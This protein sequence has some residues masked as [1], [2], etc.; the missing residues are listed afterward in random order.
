M[1]S[2]R[3][4]GTMYYAS[5]YLGG[6][7][8]RV[9]LGTTAFRV[10]KERLRKLEASLARGTLEEDRPTQTPLAD[11]V[12]AYAEYIRHTK[13]RNGQRIDLW[14]LRDIFGPVSPVLRPQGRLKKRYKRDTKLRAQ[15]LEEIRTHQIAEFIG[16]R[17]VERGI[18]PKTANRYREILMRLFNWAVRQRGLRLPGGINP[19]KAVERYRVRAPEIT[20][21]DRTQIDVQLAAL[22]GCPQIQAMVALYIFAGLRREEALWLTVHDIDLHAGRYGMIR[23]HAKTVHEERW[24]PKTKR[25]RAVTISR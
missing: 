17:V 2:L 25:N 14:Y 9:S 10:A 8:C 1:A 3:K 5:Y 4:R 21:L 11:I 19:V 18:S 24:E 22:A 20:F 7:E 15:Y 16:R 13:T 12:G 23:V 6:R